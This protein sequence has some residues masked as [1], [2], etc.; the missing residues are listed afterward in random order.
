MVLELLW[1]NKF[2]LQ[3]AFFAF[4]LVL[5]LA[6]GAAPERICAGVLL[7]MPVID[8]IHH[9]V[10]GGS[11]YYRNVDIGHLAIDVLVFCALLP[12]ALQANRAYPLWIGGTQIIS[13]V[14]H[15]YRMAIIEIDRIAYDVMQ[16][17]PSYI[18]LVAMSLGLAFHVSRRKRLGSYPSWRS[19]F[20][21][22]RASDR[23]KSPAT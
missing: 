4:L 14:A 22:T 1:N 20:A 3:H 23:K 6:K 17:M 11:V 10:V 13:L 15:V 16:V 2:L 7:A 12:V 5:A 21:P 19:S 8:Q 9:F 18:Q